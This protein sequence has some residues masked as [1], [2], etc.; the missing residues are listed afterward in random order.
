[1]NKIMIYQYYDF[2]SNKYSGIYQEFDRNIFFGGHLKIIT[3]RF[4]TLVMQDLH[5]FDVVNVEIS[6]NFKPALNLINEKLYLGDFDTTKSCEI[7][8]YKDLKNL[9]FK[10]LKGL[11]YDV[12]ESI[13]IK[14]VIYPHK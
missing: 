8:F 2:L 10:K 13:E 9:I 14:Y 3:A 11:N 1:M 5:L 6:V 12:I 4:F 7:Q